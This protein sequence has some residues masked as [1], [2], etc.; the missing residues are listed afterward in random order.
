MGRCKLILMFC[1]AVGIGAGLATYCPSATPQKEIAEG[2]KF[3]IPTRLEWLALEATASAAQY[4][5]NLANAR[6]R[7]D[8]GTNTVT[9]LVTYLDDMPHAKLDRSL[10]I[11]RRVLYAV[12]KTKG[13]DGWLKTRE[14][15]RSIT[16]VRKG[17]P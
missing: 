14:T 11:M 17:Q 12:A 16:E 6:F 5:F 13:W 4:D 2:D 3:Y 10:V 15:V 8:A 1:V 9:L 7:P